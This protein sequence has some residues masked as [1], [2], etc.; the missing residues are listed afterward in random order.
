MFTFEVPTVNMYN[1]FTAIFWQFGLVGVICIYWVSD[2][3]TANMSTVNISVLGKITSTA[4]NLSFEQID[5]SNGENLNGFYKVRFLTEQG[6]VFLYKVYR[7][8]ICK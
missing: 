3:L 8:I 1:W 4:Q 2:I 5:D 6:K 7:R